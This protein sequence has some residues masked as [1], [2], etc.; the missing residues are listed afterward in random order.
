MRRILASS[1]SA[2]IAVARAASYVR[3]ADMAAPIYR[4]ASRLAK[5][6]AVVGVVV[7]G[8]PFAAATAQ[9]QWGP[10]IVFVHHDSIGDYTWEFDD[11][12]CDPD[13]EANWDDDD[14]F[15]KQRLRRDHDTGRYYPVSWVV[16]FYAGINAQA[17]WGASNI[18]FPDG[19]TG[20]FGTSGGM[21]GVTFGANWLIPFPSQG[22]VSRGSSE[23]WKNHSMAAAM[24]HS[25]NWALLLGIKGDIDFGGMSG[26]PSM[27][28]ASCQTS[29]TTL[30][31]VR[32][33][34]GLASNQLHGFTPYVTAGLAYG[35]VRTTVGGL[36]N[37]DWKAGYAVG[38][39]TTKALGHDW[40]LNLEYLHVDLG[41][42]SCAPACGPTGTAR[43]SEN[44]F[45]VGFNR[46]FGSSQK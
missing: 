22:Q 40:Q 6:L 35:N 24:Q 44:A 19:A 14:C 4:A 5:L 28:C 46:R 15:Y 3:A 10:E 38:L 43:F 9:F 21:G 36:S 29:N 32:G 7:V 27:N 39:G 12:W 8:L 42:A 1:V 16:E 30:G 34:V 23:P 13:N 31:T 25:P 11:D 33:V 41:D 2:I 26:S 17:G 45:R 20:N 18:F 37:T